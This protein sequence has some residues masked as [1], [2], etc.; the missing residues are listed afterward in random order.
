MTS[1]LHFV[2]NHKSW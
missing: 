1:D 2:T